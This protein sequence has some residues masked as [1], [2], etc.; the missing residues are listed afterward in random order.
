MTTQPDAADY[1]RQFASFYDR[2]F[3]RTAGM[4]IAEAL[5][6][7]HPAP[8]TGTL[9]IGVGT[10]RIAVPLSEKVGA[11]TGL[12][13]SH[14]MLDGLAKAPSSTNVIPVQ[15]DIRTYTE[16]RT[17]GLI[18]GVCGVISLLTSPEDQQAAIQRAA[19]LL[20]PGGRLVIETGNRPAVEA[21][22]EGQSR[23]TFFTPY[24]EPGTGLQTH[25]TLPPGSDLWHC[26]Q[27]W[28]EADGTT[29]LGSETSRLSTPDEMDTFAKQ[30]GLTPEHS[31][32]SWELAP[33]QE[34]YPMFITTYTKTA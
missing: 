25:S 16:E 13:A 20:A 31:F 8:K 5:A 10:G 14:E 12:D 7:L 29:R 19:E 30:A 23:T 6:R 22:H 21:L 24:A 17:Y 2:L 1:G 27:I 26:T 9:E 34:W 32:S 4:P 33:Y 28:Y 18:Y 11:V 3:P 15:A